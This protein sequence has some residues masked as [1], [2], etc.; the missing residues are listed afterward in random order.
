MTQNLLAPNPYPCTIPPPQLRPQQSTNRLLLV[1]KS[2]SYPHGS[3]LRSLGGGKYRKYEPKTE[4]SEEIFC[5]PDE[6]A[7]L[8]AGEFE[9]L[10]GIYSPEQR[11]TVYHT[12]GMLAWGT[13]LRVGDTVLAQLPDSSGTMRRNSISRSEIPGVTAIIRYIGRVM[14]L[15]GNVYRFGVEI[16]VSWLYS[17]ANVCDLIRKLFIV[18]GPTSS[19]K[20]KF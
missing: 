1:D 5:T 12:K 8:S 14:A 6:V 15:Y 13:S 19:W 11:C 7:E 3:L 17:N 9:I 10:D 2:R 18:V 16:T 4:H 20:R